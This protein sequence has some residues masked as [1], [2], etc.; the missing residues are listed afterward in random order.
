MWEASD[1]E[2]TTGP[3]LSVNMKWKHA[4]VVV[5][6]SQAETKVSNT[7]KNHYGSFSSD[8]TLRVLVG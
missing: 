5:P 8:Q 6:P 1:N 3:N 7:L 4:E 2:K